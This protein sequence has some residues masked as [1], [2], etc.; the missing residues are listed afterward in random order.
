L[1][2]E[3]MYLR[4]H[5]SDF[6]YMR[7]HA[8][9]TMLK[10]FGLPYARTRPVRLF[11]NGEYTGF[12]TLM[13]APT[14]GY[15]MQRSFGAFDPE[16][17]AIFKAKTFV[18]SC[19]FEDLMGFM[20]D[21]ENATVTNTTVGEDKPTIDE[22]YFDED[23][24]DEDYFARGEHRADTPVLKNSFQCLNWFIEE[25]GKEQSAVF[26]GY[27][28]YGKRCGEA[29]VKLGR[30]DRDFGPKS[31]EK[32]M[33]DFLDG[34]FYNTSLND[35][36]NSIDINQW[37]QNFATYSIMLNLDS[38][39]SASPN[40]WYIAATEG[41]I[42]DWK[43][44]Q[45]DHNNIATRDLGAI[46]SASCGPRLV[47]WPLLQPTCNSIDT[48]ITVGRI[49]NNEENVKKYLEYVQEYMDILNNE[50]II[51]K[52]YAYGHDIKKYVVEDPFFS[53]SN[54]LDLSG[55]G[56]SGYQSLED[57][58]KWELGR[59]KEGFNSDVSPFLKTFTA[60]MEQVQLQLDAIEAGTL[61][62]DGVYD[63]GTACPDWRDINN[64]DYLPGSKVADDCPHD[65]CIGAGQCYE[66]SFFTCYGG[67]FQ[68]EECKQLSPACDSCFPYSD[69][70]TGGSNTRSDAVVESET[71]GS[72]LAVQC[73]SFSACFN[74][75][76]GICAFD[77]EILTVECQGEPVDSCKACF[78][79]S[80]CG[81]QKTNGTDPEPVIG[82]ETENGETQYDKTTN[83]ME[84]EIDEIEKNLLEDS[85]SYCLGTALSVL[86]WTF[87]IAMMGIL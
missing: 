36:S 31:M 40:N 42:D 81:A 60:R 46:C 10:A 34:K 65:F 47:Y 1:G 13:E 67:E 63:D 52:L 21:S 6:S 83:G 24:S 76:S 3:N 82:G 5:L 39:I 29:M 12:Y 16:K 56:S 19:P 68:L 86:S 44:V 32:S 35:L 49:L 23:Y 69:C 78:P 53:A 75:K 41:G 45:Y 4:N 20:I 51:D 85:G 61:P 70:G 8:S 87:A 84:A 11:L 22:D 26:E 15:V 2:M 80:R 25:I 59:G 79:N 77:G 43:I 72:E 9:H 37:L 54:M 66:N 14:Q 33:I 38:P 18:G 28:K 17:T 27:L 30:I 7:E 55:S 73:A 71:C 50:K 58:E 64:D 48:S 57:Y 74:H 62:R